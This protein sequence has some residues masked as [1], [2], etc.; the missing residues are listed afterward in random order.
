MGGPIVRA[1]E[2]AAV[3][4][5]GW[6]FLVMV[7][8]VNPPNWNAAGKQ[9]RAVTDHIERSNQQFSQGYGR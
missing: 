4:I 5:V 7:G 3:F 2:L 8:A 9:G 1:F 6:W